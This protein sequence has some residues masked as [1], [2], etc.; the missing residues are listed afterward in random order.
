LVPMGPKPHVL[1]SILVSMRFAEVSCMRVSVT[2]ERPEKVDPTGEVIAA[3][4]VVHKQP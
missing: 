1:A 3:R 2:R 4:V